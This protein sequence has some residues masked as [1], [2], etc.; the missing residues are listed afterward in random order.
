MHN[1]G[2]ERSVEGALC[3]CLTVKEDIKSLPNIK[4]AYHSPCQLSKPLTQRVGV[5]I[6]KYN[7][8]IIK[9]SI[10]FLFL[11]DHDIWADIPG[12]FSVAADSSRILRGI[13]RLLAGPEKHLSASH[14]YCKSTIYE[15]WYWTSIDQYSVSSF[16]HASNIS[17]GPRK[18]ASDSELFIFYYTITNNFDISNL[19]LKSV[20]EKFWF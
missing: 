17:P 19:F 20:D 2:S 5:N 14:Y 7:R 11:G 16:I 4:S 10:V 9:C 18:G 6:I 8:P 1:G 13:P 12:I 3:I 15:C